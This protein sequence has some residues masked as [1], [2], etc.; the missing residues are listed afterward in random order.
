V[1]RSDVDGGEHLAL[2]K[3]ELRPDI[4]TLVRA[5]A[6]FLPGDV[7]A[8]ARR[9]TGELLHRAMQI[10][11]DEGRGVILYLKRESGSEMFAPR[12][13]AGSDDRDADE[14]KPSTMSA[15]ASR[16]SASTAS[17][18]RSCATSVSARFA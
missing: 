16:S 9:N 15:R 18:P 7:F 6:E 12:G 17:V 2:V 14:R 5:H 1:Y 4:P 13:D 11:A 3:G 8:Y 10:I